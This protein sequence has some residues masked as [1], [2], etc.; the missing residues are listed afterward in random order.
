MNVNELL[1]QVSFMSKISGEDINKISTVVEE[2]SYKPDSVIFKEN[3][4]GGEM[5]IVVTGKVQICRAEVDGGMKVLSLLDNGQIFGELSVFDRLPRS[6]TAIAVENTKLLCIK[7]DRL[8]KLMN[9]DKEL[10]L[11]L[12]RQVILNLSQRLRNTNDKL[13]DKVFWGFTAKL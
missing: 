1:K 8:E 7:A 4:P 6:A 3:S 12:L 9:E 13:Q 10:G 11:L 5:F 2:C